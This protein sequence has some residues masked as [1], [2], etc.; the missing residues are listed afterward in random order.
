MARKKKAMNVEQLPSDEKKLAA[1]PAEAVDKPKK[2]SENE[3]SNHPK[4]SKFKK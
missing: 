1:K 2:L 3:L 4:F